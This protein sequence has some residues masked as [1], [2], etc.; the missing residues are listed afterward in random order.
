[1]SYKS[2][3]L[4]T[5]IAAGIILTVAYTVYA[6]G[7]YSAGAGT[8]GSWAVAILIFIG[9]G[10]AAMIVIQIL[11][12]IGYSIG[13]AVKEQHCEDKEVERIISSS[14]VED[15][16]DR[17]ISLK[18]ARAGSVCASAGFI[19]ALAS[20]AL[21][22]SPLFALHIICGGFAVSS[23]IEGGVGIYLYERG[24]RNG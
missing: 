19:A 18:S 15:E 16:M 22:V 10:A 1:M 5:S 12:N 6:L 23:F 9:I 21:G 13:V 17:L 3:R 8:L 4:I 24:V 14:M 20:L 11:F 2:K 7:K